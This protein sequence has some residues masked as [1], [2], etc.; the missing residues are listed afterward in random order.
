VRVDVS[1][2]VRA[3]SQPAHEPI[4]LFANER[5]A[6]FGFLPAALRG[7]TALLLAPGAP[8]VRLSNGLL[9]EDSRRFVVQVALRADG[10]ARID[11]NETLHGS[12]AVA[13]RGQLEQIPQAELDRRMEQDYV[14]RLFPGASLAALE[15][16]GREQDA[17]ELVLRYV[18][19]VK[20][21]ARPVAGGLALPSV[22][23]SEISSNL[24]R[25]ATRK[26]SELIASPVKTELNATIALPV[27]FSLSPTPQ[28]EKLEGAFAA[29][30]SFADTVTADAKSV[31]LQRTLSLPVMRISVADYPAFSEFCR[32]VDAV[33]GRELLLRSH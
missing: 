18:A 16:S 20:S 26:T 23:P 25:T 31:R 13:W 11:V 21:F 28:P 5:W 15:I 2:D 8:R 7:Q 30:P 9:G 29:R 33:E 4:W 17:P 32:R 27:G 10:S 22:L 14:A 12:E 19:E 6:P 3:A 24:A 1:G